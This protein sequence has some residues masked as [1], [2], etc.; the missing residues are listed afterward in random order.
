[1]TDTDH[2]DL[3]YLTPCSDDATS[4]IP[5]RTQGLEFL[6]HEGQQQLG[7]QSHPQGLFEQAIDMSSYRIAS[8]MPVDPLVGDFSDDWVTNHSLF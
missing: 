2:V 8:A 1:M 5:V 4:R 6:S 3:R 7:M